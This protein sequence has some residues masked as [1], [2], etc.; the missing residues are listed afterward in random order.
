MAVMAVAVASDWAGFS[1]TAASVV[2][3]YSLEYAPDGG[4]TRHEQWLRHA[5]AVPAATDRRA[6]EQS[7]YGGP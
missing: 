6:D 1:T 3:N 2:L 4:P 5:A 7:A